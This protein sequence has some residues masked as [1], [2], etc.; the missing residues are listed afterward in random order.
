M[1]VL[2]TS[3]SE[4]GSLQLISTGPGWRFQQ[5]SRSDSGTELPQPPI[6]ARTRIFETVDDAV[7]Y[8]RAAVSTEPVRYGSAG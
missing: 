8:F 4:H 2:V 1:K 5:W 3:L 6:D 7:S